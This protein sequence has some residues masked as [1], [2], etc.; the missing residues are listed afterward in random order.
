MASELATLAGL[1]GMGSGASDIPT[2]IEVMTSDQAL[3]EIASRSGISHDPAAARD[4]ISITPHKT[5]DSIIII[6]V[7]DESRQKAAAA[8]R[9]VVDVYNQHMSHADSTVTGRTIIA[10]RNQLAVY[11]EKLN[12]SENKLASYS[13]QIQSVDPATEATQ[14][15]T[16]LA[17][18]RKEDLDMRR[19]LNAQQSIYSDYQKQAKSLDPSFVPSLSLAPNPLIQ[20]DQTKLSDLQEE[21]SKL[22]AQYTPQDDEMV[23]NQHQIDQV[24]ADIAEEM[25]RQATT[26]SSTLGA[27]DN[28]SKT[29]AMSSS[30]KGYVVSSLTR[31]VNPVREDAK[32][33][34]V[35]AQAQI[36]ADNAQLAVLDHA[37]ANADMNTVDMP[38]KL[39]KLGDLKN[40]VGVFQKSYDELEGTLVEL[41]A[42][43]PADQS[44]ATI[45]QQPTFAKK[46]VS[47]AP[48]LYT[49][50]AGVLG[51]LLGT[52]IMF[53]LDGANPKVRDSTDIAQMVDLPVLQTLPY[54]SLERLD[55]KKSAL[56]AQSYQKLVSTL[57]FL[58]LGSKVKTLMLTSSDMQ[59][60]SSTVA[61]KLANALNRAGR[62]TILVDVTGPQP[63]I[64]PLDEQ[65]N[66]EL[67]AGG[68]VTNSKDSNL[69]IKSTSTQALDVSS[70]L[71]TGATDSLIEQL[72][73]D[74]EIIIF[75][76]PALF[77]GINAA[78]IAE[79]VDGIVFVSKLDGATRDEVRQALGLIYNGPAQV[80]GVVLND[81]R[82]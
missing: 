30:V 58:G 33:K 51:L 18:M 80:M 48:H 24:R 32:A 39:R 5:S 76:A 7:R 82:L 56:S 78:V 38:D 67:P 1:T 16:Q 22:A 49:T 72:K 73:G 60:G 23:Q 10:A 53:L 55:A 63:R 40:D 36:L 43:R 62:K 75:D 28:S 65:T 15:V 12:Q 35:A 37:I 41:N 14:L 69:L 64:V 34:L 11:R 77:D 4:Q 6:A 3:R 17:A 66:A 8:V 13:K 42:R 61:Y 44:Y 52:L 31:S 57:T 59:E 2:E 71:R 54:R 70:L 47:P 50:V 79:R 81:S 29:H 27:L 26:T 21:R 20:S 9:A 68:P 25:Q 46:P 45:L 19:D 74:A